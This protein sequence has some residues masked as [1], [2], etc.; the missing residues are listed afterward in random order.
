MTLVYLHMYCNVTSAKTARS[1]EPRRP[2]ITDGVDIRSTVTV[3]SYSGQETGQGDAQAKSQLVLLYCVLLITRSNI[4]IQLRVWLM[5]KG[6][7]RV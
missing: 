7:R 2:L 1:A 3:M 4:N 5:L 6:A